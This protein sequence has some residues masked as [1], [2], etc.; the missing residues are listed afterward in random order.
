[1]VKYIRLIIIILYLINKREL[2]KHKRQKE[3][4]SSI[5][6]NNWSWNK[7]L[8]LEKIKCRNYRYLIFTSFFKLWFFQSKIPVPFLLCY[9]YCVAT[10]WD[11][12]CT[13]T[14]EPI[15]IG[16]VAR[17]GFFVSIL[18]YSLDRMN[19]FFSICIIIYRDMRGFISLSAVGEGAK[20]L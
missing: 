7:S 1:M 17:D 19:K 15:F 18:P 8:G 5:Q 2:T 13:L 11:K 9:F 14:V 4:K 20:S 10:P 6:E 16:T 12:N 3:K